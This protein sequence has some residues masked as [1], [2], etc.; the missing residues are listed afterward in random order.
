MYTKVYAAVWEDFA[1]MFHA[2]DIGRGPQVSPAA[3][4]PVPVTGCPSL[5]R[6]QH[7][8][9]ILVTLPDTLSTAQIDVNLTQV[10]E[11]QVALK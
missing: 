9:L 3:S 11:L 4:K 1:N 5:I 10:A 6:G 8:V 2:A 7:F